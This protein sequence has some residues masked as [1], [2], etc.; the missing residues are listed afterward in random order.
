MQEGPVFFLPGRRR[1]DR[2]PGRVHA[3][4]TKQG[5]E[6]DMKKSKFFF[7][8]IVL[9]FCFILSACQ[10]GPELEQLKIQ[11]YEGMG[12]TDDE[13]K[14]DYDIL[15]RGPVSGGE[16]NLFTTEPD[17]LNPLLTKNIYVSEFLG[18]VYEGLTALNEKQQ[19]VPKLSDNWSVSADG[20]IWTFHIRDNVKWQDGQLFTA[21]DVEFTVQLL[22]NAGIDSV[23]KPLVQNIE[24]CTAVDSSNFKLVLS[25]PNSFLPE[26]MT[27]PILPAHQ[28]KQKDV[29]SSKEDF[30]PV[31]TGPYRFEA[32]TD[33]KLVSLKADRNW[34]Y[35]GTDNNGKDSM[36][37]ETVNIKVYKSTDDAIGA[38]Q[39][40]DIDAVCID[41]S[42]FSKYKGRTDLTIKKYTSRDFEM[43]AFNLNN[44]ILS[45]RYVRKAI[46]LAIDR[47]KLVSDVLPGDAY[48]SEV[49]ILPESWISGLEGVTADPSAL[50]GLLAGQNTATDVSPAGIAAGQASTGSAVKGAANVSGTTVQSAVPT[51][52]AITAATPREALLQ[53]GWK[54]STQG[55]YKTI[56][57]VRKYLQLEILVNSNNSV[58]VQAAQNICNQVSQAGIK[59]VC[60]PVEWNDLLTRVNTLKY[61]AAFIGCRVPQIP[62]LSYLYSI[63]YLPSSVLGAYDTARNISG[64]YNMQLDAYIG[65]LF[66]ESSEERKKVYYKAALEQIAKDTPYIGLYFT[67]NAVVYGK[68]LRGPLQPDTW[69][70]YN[71]F[72]HWYKPQPQ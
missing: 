60:T 5:R 15:D 70:L 35:L 29:L 45:D 55:Y 10:Y 31:G 39:T 61:D 13:Y 54:E 65:G 22:E 17:T 57:G 63:A 52:A 50:E 68:S 23:Y 30:K 48:V 8:P 38:L 44:P 33:K 14:A 42:D 1:E 7:L 12:G 62:D 4:E 46:S 43:L 2:Q 20:L 51:N 24:T 47:N 34:W 72:V 40:G 27:F 71:D 19:A 41:S 53:G 18:F 6:H 69:N 36:Y 21:S 16:L 11:Q 25:K 59:A 28:F 66:K 67:R 58:R 9:C 49:P 64:Y 37:I 56:G 3:A 26:M 32:F